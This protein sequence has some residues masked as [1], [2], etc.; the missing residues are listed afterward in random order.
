MPNTDGDK[1]S[2]RT[3]RSNSIPNT[4]T[5]SSQPNLSYQVSKDDF[6]NFKD[7]IV[8]LFKSE[9]TKV[10]NAFQRLET[11]I[12]KFEAAIN[13]IHVRTE[14]ERQASE[15]KDLKEKIEKVDSLELIGEIEDR[16]RKKNNVILAGVEELQS[17]KLSERK[18]QDQQK[19]T[20]IFQELEMEPEFDELVRIGRQQEGKD[21]LLRITLDDDKS[22]REILRK[23]KLLRSNAD[24]K[25]V[26][27][28]PDRTR[29]EQALF[30]TCYRQLQE[31]RKNGE[32]VIIYRGK[33]VE[34]E[35]L[36]R[37]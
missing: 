33:V 14:Q 16:L 35:S 28:N 13:D 7:D 12:D 3:T 18:E 15:L 21:R 31:R 36:K 32:D 30:K 1:H 27:I 5:H 2:T 10:T 8:N 29:Q 34:R 20:D 11:R 19:V 22:K 26:F 37:N 6:N 25:N 4:I 17:G 24:F 9:F 23:A